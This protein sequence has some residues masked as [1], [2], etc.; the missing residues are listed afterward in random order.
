MSIDIFRAVKKLDA[1]AIV[2]LVNMAYRPESGAYGWMH[3]SD[4]VSGSRTNVDQ[5]VDII[6]KPDSVILLG[7][8]RSEIVAS[9]HIEKDGSNCY[10]GMFAVNPTLQGVG[11]GKQMLASRMVR[12]RKFQLR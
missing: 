9:I 3:E 8:K 4:F 2:N 7:I 10:I 11:V 5:L 12:Q 1:E 6:S